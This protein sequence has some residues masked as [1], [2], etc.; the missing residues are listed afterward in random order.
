MM[1]ATSNKWQMFKKLLGNSEKFEIIRQ[2]EA[3]FAALEKWFIRLKKQGFKT[4]MS[5]SVAKR[6][7]YLAFE[8]SL[9]VWYEKLGR[10][11]FATFM[12][13]SVACRLDMND[14]AFDSSLDVWYEK[15]GAERFVTFM[16]NS[17]ACRLG[18]NDTAFDSSLN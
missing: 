1:E 14:T 15:L 2:D 9:D 16:S 7:G 3:A 8:S 18:M 5:Y 4:L 13:N 10:K 6:I 11:G 17:V 12:S